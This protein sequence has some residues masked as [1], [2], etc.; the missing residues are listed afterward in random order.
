MQL[1]GFKRKA[2]QLSSKNPAANWQQIQNQ[3]AAED[4]SF[5]SKSELSETASSVDESKTEIVGIKDQFQKITKLNE[6]SHNKR[7]RKTR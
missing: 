4:L 1:P 6:R 5:A 2:H 7:N 3:T